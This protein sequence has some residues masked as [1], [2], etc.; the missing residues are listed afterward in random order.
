MSIATQFDNEMPT[1]VLRGGRRLARRR[2]EAWICRIAI[3]TLM[4]F[5]A[6]LA[7]PVLVAAFSPSADVT[8][9]AAVTEDS[10]AQ[11]E[12]MAE[13][14]GIRVIPIYHTEENSPQG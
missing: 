4:V 14:A 2:V 7:E 8:Q 1:I 12:D 6:V 9:N 13:H 5:G 11:I 10:T 3:A